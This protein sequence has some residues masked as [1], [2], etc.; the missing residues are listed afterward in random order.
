MCISDRIRRA[1]GADISAACGQLRRQ[2]AD[3]S[4][5]GRV[6]VTEGGT[7]CL[8]D[9]ISWGRWFWLGDRLLLPFSV[10]AHHAL[11]DGVHLGQFIDALQKKLD[12]F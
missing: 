10:Q 3:A 7:M 4:T 2:D 8:R 9:R 1:L 11:V 12:A 6:P 5:S